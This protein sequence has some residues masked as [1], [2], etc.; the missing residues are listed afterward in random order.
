MF[1]RVYEWFDTRSDSLLCFMCIYNYRVDNVYVCRNHDSFV[2]FVVWIQ[3]E[4]IL[5]RAEIMVFSHSVITRTSA[6]GID[7]IPFN[8]QYICCPFFGVFDFILTLVVTSD[9]CVLNRC[10]PLGRVFDVAI[11]Q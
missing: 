5:W 11:C 7:L 9:F 10:V 2:V 6:D 8:I 3:L 1:P 4:S